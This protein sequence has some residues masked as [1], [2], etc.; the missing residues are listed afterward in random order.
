MHLPVSHIEPFGPMGRLRRVAGKLVEGKVKLAIRVRRGPFSHP[1]NNEEPKEDG[2]EQQ[3]IH[4]LKY[5]ETQGGPGQD[6]TLQIQLL[7]RFSGI[8]DERTSSPFQLCGKAVE[9]LVV[10]FRDYAPD[11]GQEQE[12]ALHTNQPTIPFPGIF[13]TLIIASSLISVTPSEIA[14]AR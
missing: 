2:K 1:K 10:C 4:S 8:E 13:L 11:E 7:S 6:I 12:E 5:R 3:Q 14:L 9:R